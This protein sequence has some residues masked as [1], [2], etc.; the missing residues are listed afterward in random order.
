M[1]ETVVLYSLTAILSACVAALGFKIS[2]K[3]K[4]GISITKMAEDLA[5]KAN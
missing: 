4:G 3:S 1:G 2:D 5:N